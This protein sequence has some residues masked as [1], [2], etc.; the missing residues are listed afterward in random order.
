MLKANSWD[1]Y[2]K[3]SFC[4]NLF[5]SIV[6]ELSYTLSK[7]S[8]DKLQTLYIDVYFLI[9][10]TVDVLA[11][12]FAAIFSKTPTTTRRLVLSGFLGAIIAVI[13]VLLPEF[14]LLKLICSL[15]G[16][17]LMGYITPRTARI[18]RK[19]KFLFS[20]LIFE[21]LVGGIVSFFWSFLDK[22]LSGSRAEAEG[23]AVNRKML[24]FS[25][26]VLLSI[27]VFKMIVSFFSNVQSEGSALV[28]IKFMENKIKLE[29]FVDSGN[30]AIDPMDMS[31]IL[32]IKKDIAKTFLPE[33]IIELSDI[34]SLDRN[35][36]KRIRLIPVSLGGT[37]SVL[38]GVKADCVSVI[39]NGKNEEINVTLAIDKEGGSYGGYL[40]LM[41]SAALSDVG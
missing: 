25:L 26:I 9:N 7:K 24:L 40:G 38:T 16:L 27:G 21:S 4:D 5:G 12:Y 22:N 8:G 3:L 14:I 28:E 15:I 13:T 34:D 41:P 32:L 11:L 35:I 10:F 31:P 37:T 2:F 6:L 33:N 23:G 18:G 20:F 39:K 36:K 29:A 17:M 30:L 1:F 19:M